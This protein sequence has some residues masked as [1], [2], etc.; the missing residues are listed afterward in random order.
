[1]LGELLDGRYQVLQVLSTGGFG[2]TYIAEDTRRP[3]NPRCVVKHLKPLSTDPNSLPIARR[4]F[5]SEAETLEQLGNHDQIPR[6]LAYFEENQEFYLVQEL[7]VGRPLSTELHPGQPWSESQVIQMLED[8]LGILA[9]VHGYGVIHRD[10]KPDNLIRRSSDGKLVLIDFGAVKQV[11]TQLPIDG[12]QM[13]STVAIGTPGYVPREQMLGRPRPN[14]DIYALGIIGIQAATGLSPHQLPEDPTTQEILWQHQAHLSAGLNYFLSQMV[15]CDD[16]E[17][18]Q[19]ATQALAVLQQLTSPYLP[20]QLP[21]TQR[22]LAPPSQQDAPPVAAAANKVPLLIGG[23]VIAVGMGFAIAYMTST[24]VPPPISQQTPDS[25]P[26]STSSLNTNPSPN[27]TPKNTSSPS[28]PSPASS[29]NEF[30]IAQFPQENCGD[31]VPTTSSASTQF[32]PV[33]IKYNETNLQIAKSKFCTDAYQTKRKDTGEVAIQMASF[34]NRDRAEL[35]SKFLN[36]QL[37]SGEVGQPT[38][39]SVA[40]KSDDSTAKNCVTLVS[41]PDSPLN[42]RS[43]PDEKLSNIV[44]TLENETPLT[45]VTEQNGWLKIS[46]PVEGW[47]S[48]KR[49]KNVCQ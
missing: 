26:K 1:M 16:R 34:T 33:F 39:H 12:N 6:L 22:S 43:T 37:G 20:T 44:S 31:A 25:T 14:S 49:T 41:D 17:R 42:V 24:S 11:R 8:V 46:A 30:D 47:V 13:G 4:L 48:K 7:I 10:I 19:S 45:V 28:S 40:T 29:S 2:E 9:F 36:Q 5:R 35:F 38:T 32:Y 21:D 18:Y 27:S 15:R 23:M 3:G